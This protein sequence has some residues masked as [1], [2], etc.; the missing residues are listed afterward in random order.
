MNAWHKSLRDAKD[1]NGNK[2]FSPK[3]DLDER[4]E[5]LRKE[6]RETKKNYLLENDQQKIA[7]Q[8][9][10]KLDS[11]I[12]NYE[13]VRTNPKDPGNSGRPAY[14]RI[15]VHPQDA[16]QVEYIERQR[17]AS[18]TMH[19]QAHYHQVLER[20]K[21]SRLRK[22]IELGDIKSEKINEEKRVAKR[23]IE[24]YSENKEVANQYSADLESARLKLA[25]AARNIQDPHE[26]MRLSAKASAVEASRERFKKYQT[27]SNGDAAKG[28]EDFLTKT[29]DVYDNAKKIQKEA[30]D[31]GNE[32]DTAIYTGNRQGLALVMD[33]IRSL[34]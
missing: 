2:L 32:I 13:T 33:K 11:E 10:E 16:E 3:G 6:L 19:K 17:T 25:L 4:Q 28:V 14:S 30:Q 34:K 31:S 15:A 9:L 27:A 18:L 12:G 8:R 23:R 7:N 20:A 29:R 21:M 22:A 1:S 24:K 5:F 26:R